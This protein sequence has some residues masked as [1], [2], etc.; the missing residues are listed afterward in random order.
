MRFLKSYLKTIRQYKNRTISTKKLHYSKTTLS[1]KD[2]SWLKSICRLLMSNLTVA[3]GS[4]H[5]FQMIRKNKFSQI[6]M[7]LIKILRKLIMSFLLSVMIPP[8]QALIRPNN[9]WKALKKVL[10]SWII[11]C[12]QQGHNSIP[13]QFIQIRNQILI[14][15]IGS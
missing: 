8:V 7:L 4:V 6:L 5:Y 10:K 11:Y 12:H 2:Y 3:N 14:Q 9:N 15:K 13:P 1:N